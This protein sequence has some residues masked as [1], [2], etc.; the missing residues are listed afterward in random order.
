MKSL[1]KLVG[2]KQVHKERKKQKPSP[3]SVA[4]AVHCHNV[5]YDNILT[6]SAFIQCDG[7]SHLCRVPYVHEYVW[8]AVLHVCLLL[9]I[10]CL[11]FLF[12]GCPTLFMSLMIIQ[13][14]HTQIDGLID[15]RMDRTPKLL[16]LLCMLQKKQ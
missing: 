15:K 4:P 13:V 14:L 11:F 16:L 5:W 12:L 1:L 6:V 3:T 9:L 10:M 2:L 7:M 8:E